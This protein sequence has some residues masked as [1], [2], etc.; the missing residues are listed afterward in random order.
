MPAGGSD[1]AAAA[2]APR[3]VWWLKTKPNGCPEMG[4][5]ATVAAV[6]KDAEWWCVEGGKWI[7]NERKG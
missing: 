1:P 4:C 7:P 2:R 5:V 3:R 6:P